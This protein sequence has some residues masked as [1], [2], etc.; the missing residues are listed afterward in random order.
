MRRLWN[1][2]QVT[3]W[4]PAPRT[5]TWA[6]KRNGYMTVDINIDPSLGLRQALV[7]E[8]LE[9]GRGQCGGVVMP[10]WPLFDVLRIPAA[11]MPRLYL[12]PFT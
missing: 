6:L 10:P 4:G 9:I 11:I 1:D 12:R 8:L 2:F 5:L 3:K 7:R